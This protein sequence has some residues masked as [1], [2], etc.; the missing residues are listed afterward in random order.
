VRAFF[1]DDLR[2]EA[3]REAAR[4]A[5]ITLSSAPTAASLPC[6]AAFTDSSAR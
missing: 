1:R 6:R 4:L 2:D 3:V 5:V